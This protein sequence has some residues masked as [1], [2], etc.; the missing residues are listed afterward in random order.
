MSD[1]AGGRGCGIIRHTPD[2]RFGGTIS[3]GINRWSSKL[4]YWLN[5]GWPHALLKLQFKMF[6]TTKQSSNSSYHIRWFRHP[7]PLAWPPVWKMSEHCLHP[8]HRLRRLH[9]LEPIHPIHPF[10]F[11]ILLSYFG[12]A[13][14]GP[15]SAWAEIIFILY[16]RLSMTEWEAKLD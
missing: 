10:I 11:F 5:L 9:H 13:C 3:F 15:P 12:Q 1:K 4:G 7:D 14:A 16:T 8:L 6:R 2:W